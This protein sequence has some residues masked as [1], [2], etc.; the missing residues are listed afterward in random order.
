M[1]KLSEIISKS[2]QKTEALAGDM[3]RSLIPGDIIALYGSVGAGKTQ[4]VRGLAA[5]LGCTASVKSPSFNLINE[6]PGKIPLYHIDFYRLESEGEITDLGWTDYLNS[7]GVVVI[8][9][10]ERV[11]NLLPERAIDVYFYIL[12]ENSR[13]LE[14]Y[15]NDDFRNRQ[16]E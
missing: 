5:G 3:A 6:Y 12:E 7:D 14:I 11:K 16:L 2:V 15:V 9:W 13:K 10:A 4:F 1:I 8:E